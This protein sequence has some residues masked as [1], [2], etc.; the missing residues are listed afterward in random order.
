[1]EDYLRYI[2]EEILLERLRKLRKH[3]VWTEARE[4]RRTGGDR[5]GPAAYRVSGPGDGHVLRHIHFL[6]RRTLKKF[7]YPVDVCLNYAE[8]ARTHKSFGHMSRIYAE[9]LQH[10]PRNEGLWIEAASFEFFGYVAQDYDDGG[11][12]VN[13]KVVGSS[14]Q[15]AR[16]L[17]QRGLRINGKTS[18]ELCLQYFALE[19]HYVQNLKGRKHILEDGFNDDG[20]THND[21]SFDKEDDDSRHDDSKD[22]NG[23]KNKEKVEIGDTMLLPSIVIYK[24]AIKAI[25]Q[26]ISFRLRFV[27]VYRMFPETKQLERYVMDTVEH[28]FGKSVEGWV[29]RISYEEEEW[30]RKLKK[31]RK[32]MGHSHEEDEKQIGFLAKANGNECHKEFCDKDDDDEKEDD[33][34]KKNALVD[35]SSFIS[36]DDDP[37]LLLLQQALEAVPTPK[38]YLECARFLRLRIQRLLDSSQN[39]ENSEENDEEE[40]VT[41]LLYQ[42]EDLEAHSRGASV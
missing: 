16:V 28:D 17:M 21:G 13:S 30:K 40:D 24:N 26:N 33:R 20:S 35:G 38:M 29:A 14:I 19:L 15:N 42:E 39:N 18:Q 37:S 3:T 41:F 8:F 6:Y 1:M 11:E 22:E 5:D 34:P 4:R 2:E 36:K 23:E 7:H 27:E 10:H 32:K 12:G 25:P 31:S 9:A